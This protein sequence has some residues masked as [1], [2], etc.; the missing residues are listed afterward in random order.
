MKSVF[1]NQSRSVTAHARPSLLPPCVHVPL[2]LAAS[3]LDVRPWRMQPR[4]PVKPQ[5]DISGKVTTGS[6]GAVDKAG[7]GGLR[8][9][10]GP[11]PKSSHIFNLKT[12]SWS[13]DINTNDSASA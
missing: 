9:A 12:G 8:W 3:S 7:G 13:L 5:E 1:Q 11:T 10:G 2:L 6:F 4:N